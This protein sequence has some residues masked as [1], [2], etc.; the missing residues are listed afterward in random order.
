M[1][2]PTPKLRNG[3][4]RKLHVK[5]GGDCQKGRLT[6]HS[7]LGCLL[8]HG[9]PPAPEEPEWDMVAQ[10]QGKALWILGL[11]GRKAKR[12]RVCRGGRG[13]RLQS[14]SYP[15][16]R[17]SLSTGEMWQRYQLKGKWKV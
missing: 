10:P 8:S 11:E 15:L 4:P 12:R 6:H 9:L 16:S 3:S 5:F 17:D 14:C 7:L 1:V 13:W 2:V